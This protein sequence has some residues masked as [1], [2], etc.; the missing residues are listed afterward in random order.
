MSAPDR[1]ALALEERAE[2]LELLRGLTADEW[3]AESLCAPWRV[4]D[5][6]LHV[7]SYDELST[8][9]LVGTFLRGGLRVSSVNEAALERYADLG[10][11]DIIELVARTLWPRGLTS[12]FGGGIALTDGMIHQQDIRRPLGIP[13]AIDPHRLRAVLDFALFAPTLPARR[14]SRGLRLVATDIEWEVGD[15]P[16]VTGPG[17]ALLMAIAGR[18]LALDDLDGRGLV[19]LRRRITES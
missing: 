5:V 6:A 4:R 18:P 3:D 2:L 9:S 12:G 15:G 16:E 10:P 11:E 8:L 13:R 19:S 17:E 14:H 7:V 1:M